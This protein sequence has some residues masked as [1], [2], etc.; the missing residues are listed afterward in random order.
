M[1]ILGKFPM[2]ISENLLIRFLGEFPVVLLQIFEVELF[3]ESLLSVLLEFR[4]ES[5][6]FP[7]EFFNN[8]TLDFVKKLLAELPDD[9]P[10]EYLEQF[11]MEYLE[12][13]PMKL[14][15]ELSMVLLKEFLV[16]L[17]REYAVSLLAE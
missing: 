1:E 7:V 2:E 14:L 11:P 15:D 12:E 17:L 5:L 6:D 4:L 10:V 8:M 9:L 13:F 16:K 3:W